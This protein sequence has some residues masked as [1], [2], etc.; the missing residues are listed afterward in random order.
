MLVCA[1]LGG[2]C[3]PESTAFVVVT[4]D[5]RAPFCALPARLGCTGRGVDLVVAEPTAGM[6]TK[7]SIEL[8]VVVLEGRGGAL[9]SER[10]R[11]GAS[12]PISTTELTGLSDIGRG[13]GLLSGKVAV[14][15]GTYD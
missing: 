15:A 13:N 2:N 5:S 10:T 11:D 3:G 1:L 9:D 14:A 7:L 4:E 12:W 8:G 6:C